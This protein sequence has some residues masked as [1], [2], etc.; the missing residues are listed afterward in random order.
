M[1][2]VKDYSHLAMANSS[3]SYLLKNGIFLYL[4]LPIDH[5]KPHSSLALEVGKG[6]SSLTLYTL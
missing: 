3:A 5:H 6:I 4:S 1:R 2:K